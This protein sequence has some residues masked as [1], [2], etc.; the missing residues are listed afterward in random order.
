MDIK[1][2]TH[3]E[4]FL[5]NICA[6]IKFKECH[7]EVKLELQTHIEDKTLDYIEKGLKEDDAIKKAIEDMGDIETIGKRLNIAHKGGFDLGIILLSLFLTFTGIFSSY[8]ICYNGY[9]EIQGM[10]LKKLLVSLIL[11]ILVSIVLYMFNYKKLKKH[12]FKIFLALIFIMVFICIFGSRV[13]GSS[14]LYI[15]GH[16]FSSFNLISIL[17]LSICGILTKEN[18]TKRKKIIYSFILFVLPSLLI[19]L[20]PDMGGMLVYTIVFAVILFNCNYKLRHILPVISINIILFITLI[21]DSK[22]FVAKLTSFLNYKG[23]P[24]GIGY[25]HCVL[26]KTIHSA[27][28]FGQGKTNYETIIYLPSRESDFIFAY[29]TNTFGW[30]GA[31]ILTLCIALFIIKLY[32]LS[33]KIKDLYGKVLIRAFT[34]LLAAQFVFNILMNLNMCP[35]TGIGLPF[36]S[37]GGS[38]IFFNLAII[39]FIMSIYRRKDIYTLLNVES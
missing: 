16:N 11:G 34:T 14:Y 1:N 20:I 26:Q 27:G 6:F 18:L 2:N 21:L 24:E 17:I 38:N 32:K 36:I 19:M 39:G 31:V 33:Y 12:S 35:I 37:Y 23:D 9:T 15:M 22:Y 13:N 25:I 28:F 29:I 8:L 4:T 30:I 10:D 3:V 7:E 5:N